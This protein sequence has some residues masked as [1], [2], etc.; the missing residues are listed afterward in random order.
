MAS[1]RAPFQYSHLFFVAIIPALLISPFIPP[2]PKRPQHLPIQIVY[3]T[4]NVES[5]TLQAE[6]LLS[7]LLRS[8]HILGWRCVIEGWAKI[9]TMEFLCASCPSCTRGLKASWVQPL[10]YLCLLTAPGHTWSD[11]DI[12]SWVLL[13]LTKLI[14]KHFLMWD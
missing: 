6:C 1:G 12:I 10:Y 11:R 4:I 3:P 13:L 9:Q 8:R 7:K 14:L 2:P 5:S